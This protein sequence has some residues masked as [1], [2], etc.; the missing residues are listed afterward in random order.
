MSITTVRNIPQT[1][2]LQLNLCGIGH[3]PGK[4]SQPYLQVSLRMMVCWTFTQRQRHILGVRGAA[5]HQN[6]KTR[7]KLSINSPWRP[8]WTTPL[9]VWIARNQSVYATK[10]MLGSNGTTKMPPIHFSEVTER[11]TG[12]GYNR[13][14]QKKLRNT[15]GMGGQWLLLDG[16]R[17]YFSTARDMARFWLMVLNNGRRE[18]HRIRIWHQLR[19]IMRFG[20][21]FKGYL[22]SDR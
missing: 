20:S 6:R 8:V 2:P 4:P 9:A 15:T 7:F 3:R 21:E 5:L 12:D 10:L 18:M 13:Y 17:T 22:K 11:A 16:N 19:F 14:T 1:N